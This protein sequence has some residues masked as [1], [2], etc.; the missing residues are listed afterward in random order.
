MGTASRPGARPSWTNR[1]YLRG[2]TGDGV[3]TL[4]R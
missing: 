4:D 1:N 2:N 3:R